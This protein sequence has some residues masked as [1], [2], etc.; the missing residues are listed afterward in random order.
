MY[1]IESSECCNRRLYLKKP[2]TVLN[3]CKMSWTSIFVS[4]MVL[5]MSR[6]KAGVK[7]CSRYVV[8]FSYRLVIATRNAK[9]TPLDSFFPKHFSLK[10]IVP[11]VG[12]N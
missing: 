9:N 8:V 12:D 10:D 6:W 1:V 7:S 3:F 4:E 11:E 2:A 5:V